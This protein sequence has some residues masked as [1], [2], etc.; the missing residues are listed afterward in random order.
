MRTDH[1]QWRDELEEAARSGRLPADPVHALTIKMVANIT[2][3]IRGL[4]QERQGAALDEITGT[5]QGRA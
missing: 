3:T 1:E 2:H 4:P 5:L